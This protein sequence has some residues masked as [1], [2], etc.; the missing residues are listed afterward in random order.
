M[1][2]KDRKEPP[3]GFVSGPA[4]ITVSES[5]PVRAAF[6]IERE[7]MNSKF[8]TIVQLSTG[9]AGRRVEVKNKVW[10]QSKGVSLKA[11]FPLKVKNSM[12]TYNMGLGTI[13]RGTNDEKKY[14]VPSRE[15]F[16]LTDKSGSFGV[17][18]LEDCKFGSDKPNDST[19]RLTL[20]YTPLANSFPD[21]A[22]Q[23]WGIHEFT[24]ALYSHKGDWRTGQTEWQG[25]RLNQPMA[26]FLSRP[27]PGSLGKSFSFARLSSP[28][29]D[30]RAIKKTEAGDAILFRIQELTGKP[31]GPVELILAG[32][33][34][35]AWETDG[36]ERKTADLALTGGKLILELD[37]F[38]IRSIAVKLAPSDIG[39]TPAASYPQSLLY[40][41][42][43]VTSDSNRNDG[44]FNA[45]G[46]S[47][48]A[49]LFPATLT[50]DGI[51]FE[52]GGSAENQFNAVKCFGQKIDLPKTGNFNKIYILAAAVTDTTGIFRLGGQ[53]KPVRI[54]PITGNIGQYDNR[55]WDEYGR[56]ASLDPGFI[57]R[58]PVAWYSTHLHNDTSN[59]PYRFGYIY[60]YEL[61]A[62]PGSE[63]IQLPENESIMIFALTLAENAY[64]HLAEAG[65]LYDDFTGREKM[66]LKLETRYVI[67]G[68]QPTC[69]DRVRKETKPRQP[70]GQGNNEGLCRHSY[71]Q[72][73][74]GPVCFT[75][76]NGGQA[77]TGP[78][79]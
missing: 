3:A 62:G 1:D 23:D 59:I 43:I 77:R 79:T 65:P 34:I 30:I 29:A 14:E 50:V 21:Q 74:Y 17:S 66:E 41:W 38:A 46:H 37:P 48:P 63:Y 12:A 67:P 20:L 28:Q 8:V 32:K 71:A 76:R 16:D 15:W 44:S 55:K 35:S 54:Q 5:G 56:I 25:R 70:A 68:M 39:T 64:G 53:K 31:S 2:W 19:L 49:E 47:F 45:S 6:R 58:D 10:W 40:N 61:D 13:E 60:K 52:M 26:A 24:F 75:N 42:D 72:W 69:H 9:E 33:V 36:Q 73:G 78:L 27:H 7:A 18:V 51:R 11:T 22:T 4:K 57:R